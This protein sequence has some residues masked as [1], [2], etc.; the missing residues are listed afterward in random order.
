MLLAWQA[1][2]AGVVTE[3]QIEAGSGPGLANIVVFR[4]GS[5]AP[6]LVVSGVPFNTYFVRVR[7]IEN[8]VAADASNEVVIVV[9]PGPCNNQVTP[10]TITAPAGG[11]TA[12]VTVLSN[13][14]W[15]AV[16][17][18]PFVTITSGSP[19]AGNGTVTLSIAPN[20]GGSR[21]GTVTVA[22]TI[23][24]VTQGAG[25][26]V[27]AFQFFD[28]STQATATTECRIVGNPTTC[29]LRST[30]FT[31]GRN[32]IVQWAWTVT[33]TYVEAKTITQTGTDPNLS[34]SEVCGQTGSGA[35]GP[36]Q[37][38]NVTLTVTDNEGATA[39]RHA[40]A[41]AVSPRST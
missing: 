13:C 24:T 6:G 31:F 38:V 17:N 26:L 34:F 25:S 28:P 37:P 8:G 33:Y 30:S 41:V 19:G 16:S 39:T 7:H 5:T 2:A 3:Y 36:A 20:P 11:S 12:T 23:V 18:A 15:S 22:D 10:P 29:Q 4:T 35:D 32:F 27:S 40:R 14:N 21:S 1:P 9:S